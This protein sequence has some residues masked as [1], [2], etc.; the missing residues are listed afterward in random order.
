VLRRAVLVDDPPASESP[1]WVRM[2]EELGLTGK[3]IVVAFSGGRWFLSVQVDTDGERDRAAIGTVCGVDLGS[4]TLATIAGGD[5][6][7]EP[8]CGPKPAKQLLGR[9]KRMQRRISLQKHRAEKAGVR[10]SRRQQ[11]RQ[12]RL[13]KLEARLAEGFAAAVRD[14][15]NRRFECVQHG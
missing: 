8:V 3:I 4:R 11:M 9:I 13:C 1:S 7:I 12:L 14:N 5:N 10:T 2:F 6:A 15:R